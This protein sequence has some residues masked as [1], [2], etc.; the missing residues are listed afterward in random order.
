[1]DQNKETPPAT[2]EP[3]A[4]EQQANQSVD[5]SDNKEQNSASTSSN[6]NQEPT[7]ASSAANSITLTIKTPKDKE[8]VNVSPNATVKEVNFFKLIYLSKKF[9]IFFS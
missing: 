7:A 5:K 9:F 1:M 3:A 2:S 8:T 6:S 4:S